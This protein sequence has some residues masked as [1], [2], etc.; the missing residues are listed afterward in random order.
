MKFTKNLCFYAIYFSTWA[1]SSNR[2]IRS[3][4]LKHLLKTP[5]V[6][7]LK[8]HLYEGDVVNANVLSKQI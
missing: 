8:N 6:Q 3:K 4:C 1:N 2:R 5:E 7:G